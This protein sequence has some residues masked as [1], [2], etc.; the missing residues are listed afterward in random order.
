[1][2]YNQSIRFRREPDSFEGFLF[3]NWIH[4]VKIPFFI[5]RTFYVFGT[6]EI[7]EITTYQF[8][9][10]TV[11]VCIWNVILVVANRNEPEGPT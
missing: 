3:Y 5:Y 1:M 10:V 4:P 9:S 11:L 8:N 6:T 7:L 2:F